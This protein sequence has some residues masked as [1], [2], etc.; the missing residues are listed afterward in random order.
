MEQLRAARMSKANSMWKRLFLIVFTLGLLPGDPAMAAGQRSLVELEDKVAR[1]YPA[2][3]TLLP[4][5]LELLRESG[6]FLLLDVRD[7]AEY[8]VSHLPGAV[9]VDPDIATAEFMRRFAS[10]A[11]GKLVVLYCS[12]GVRSSR[13]AG[14]VDRSL[15]D[16]GALGAVNLRGGIFAWHNTGR[17]LKGN[18]GR[19]DRIHPY[20]RHWSYYLDF[21]NYTS[22]GGAAR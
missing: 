16:A 20:S 10:K 17:K 3:P 19:E 13:L 2:A 5:G 14:R 21:D 12:V 6:E 9:H 15:K 22:Y 1:D 7:R 11:Q 4:E 18:E 8:D